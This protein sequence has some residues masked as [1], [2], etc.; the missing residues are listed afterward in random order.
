MVLGAREFR[1]A[2][3]MNGRQPF[4]V[5]HRSA[6]GLE[7]DERLQDMRAPRLVLTSP[8]Y[9]GV[10]VL[11]HRWQVDG[12]KESPA[13]FWVANCQDGQ[14]QAHYCFGH[15]KQRGLTTY[16]N[17][18]RDSFVGVRQV[19]DPCALVVQMVAFSE[20]DWQIPRYLESMQDAG[21]D[22]LAGQ[23]LLVRELRARALAPRKGPY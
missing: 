16:F 5:L 21:F 18:I 10:H 23:E 1:A 17:G 20:P 12:R 11:Y 2:V 7:D 4:K 9:P 14:G 22:D 8:P 19:I 3:K 15:R 13:P 6:A